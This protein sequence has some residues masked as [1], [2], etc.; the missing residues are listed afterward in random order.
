MNNVWSPAVP[1][2]SPA[3]RGTVTHA[4]AGAA[5]EEVHE[6]QA[7]PLWRVRLAWL[8]R[9][10]R[11]R[12][13]RTS[14][15]VRAAPPSSPYPLIGQR[16]AAP[17]PDTSHLTAI[18]AA[19]QRTRAAGVS[20]RTQ[21]RRLLSRALRKRQRNSASCEPLA[22]DSMAHGYW[23]RTAHD[24]LESWYRKTLCT[25]TCEPLSRRPAASIL[26]QRV[27][28]K[29]AL[30]WSCSQCLS[31]ERP[32]PP[33]FRPT[34]D[35]GRAGRPHCIRPGTATSIAV[36]TDITTSACPR[37]VPCRTGDRSPG[38]HLITPPLTADERARTPPSARACA[39]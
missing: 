1:V 19:V 22:P 28:P 12:A 17:H 36:R 35:D 32:V 27:D 3:A 30:A 33:P 39:H 38:W 37:I 6:P 34:R 5:G 26:R 7:V 31:S 13:P 10:R 24:R 16:L 15:P 14:L 18:R 23:T 29:Y 25:M 9:H 21:S 4:G 8:V 11:Q 20:F 2:L